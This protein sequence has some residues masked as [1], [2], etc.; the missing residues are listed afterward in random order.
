MN[1]RVILDFIQEIGVLK[2]IP[3]T[4]WRFRGIKDAESVA[5]HCYRVSLL[6]MMLADVLKAEDIPLDVEKVMRLALLHEIAEARIGDVPFPALDYIP[7]SVK[8]DAEQAAVSAMLVNFGR[9]GEQYAKLWKEFEEGTSLEAKLV[10]AVDK[11][12]LMIQVFEYEKVGYRSLDRFWD[13]D[14]NQQSFDAY[15]QIREIMDVLIE[16]R[17]EELG[18]CA[19]KPKS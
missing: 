6:S 14:W 4:G 1:A 8:E 15:P 7:E 12:E 17:E 9:L 2:N 11:L 19:K 18:R 3:R 10:R 13:N 5:D 16:K